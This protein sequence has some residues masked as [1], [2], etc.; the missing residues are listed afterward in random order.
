[1]GPPLNSRDRFLQ[2]IEQQFEA[3]EEEEE[4][5]SLPRAPLISPNNPLAAAG[6]S[7]VQ[8]DP[9]GR[10]STSPG[11]HTHRWVVGRWAQASIAKHPLSRVTSAYNSTIKKFMD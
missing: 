9:E 5:L 6:H 7:V 2:G 4:P 11:F 1:M 8:F 3:E 10:A